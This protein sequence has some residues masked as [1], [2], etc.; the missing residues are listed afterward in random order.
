MW[1][2]GTGDCAIFF[3]EKRTC[4]SWKDPH[5]KKGQVENTR[6]THC[7]EGIWLVK[8]HEL[9]AKL[10]SQRQFGSE[11]EFTTRLPQ[12]EIARGM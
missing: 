1:N 11:K 2:K 3:K 5:T 8:Q 10:A 12:S 4:M 6:R 9:G 7:Y